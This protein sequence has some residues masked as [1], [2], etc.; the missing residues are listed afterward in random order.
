MSQEDL[1]MNSETPVIESAKM[2][3]K[4]GK[5]LYENGPKNTDVV[6]AQLVADICASQEGL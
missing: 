3:I 1:V 2:L 4:C 6:A 5:R